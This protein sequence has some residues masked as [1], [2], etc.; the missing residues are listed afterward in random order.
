MNENEKISQI[1][2]RRLR[3]R[4]ISFLA[5]ESIAEHISDAERE[6]LLHEVIEKVED[7]LRSLI[8]DIENDHNVHNTARRIARMYINETLKGRYHKAPSWT[9]FPNVKRL[10]ELYTLGPITVRST[11]SHHLVPILGDL[12]VGVVP[13]AR[14]IGISKFNRITDWIMSRPHIQ[15]EAV[16]MLADYLE[17]KIEPKGLAIV[18]R[19]KHF[20]MAWRGVKDA[21]TV[22]TNFVMRGD[23]LRDKGLEKRFFDMI[24]TQDF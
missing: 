10:D 18:L 22:M 7:L 14:V 9:E 20:C 1:I 12:W 8:I 6:Q 5:N 4:N 17:K 15:E 2:T 3:N 13:S 21:N 24:R 11:C 16:I 19:A 23:F